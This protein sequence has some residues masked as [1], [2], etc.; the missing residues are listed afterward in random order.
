MSKQIIS[1]HYLY[2]KWKGVYK[3]VRVPVMSNMLMLC[4][5]K[6]FLVIISN[7]SFLY[8]L[9]FHVKLFLSLNQQETPSNACVNTQKALYIKI[10]RS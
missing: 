8:A 4:N 5:N 2:G 9:Y 10:K 1:E 6:I 3:Y 7:L